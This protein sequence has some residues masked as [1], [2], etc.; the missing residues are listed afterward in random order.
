MQARFPPPKAFTKPEIQ[1]AAQP[2]RRRPKTQHFLASCSL[3]VLLPFLRVKTEEYPEVSVS[4]S[5]T[6]PPAPPAPAARN[7]SIEA[8]RAARLKRFKRERV[9]IDYL[10]RGVSVREIAV[11]M[12]V[13]EKRA[14]AIVKE[15]LAAHTPGPPEE[16][17]AMHHPRHG[18]DLKA[19]DRVVMR[20]SLTLASTSRSSRGSAVSTKRCWSP[21]APCRG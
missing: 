2:A 11:Q 17:A 8:R 19:V 9:V 5:A 18:A 3:Y 16:F 7:R 4:A 13:T 1:S 20:G 10:N 15:A 12:G 21:T 6:V 14:R